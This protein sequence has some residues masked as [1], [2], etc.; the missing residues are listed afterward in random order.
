M[1]FITRR[2]FAAGVGAG[3]LAAPAV[4]RAQ[5]LFTRYPF[6]LGIASGDPSPDGFVIWTRL[7]PEP[8][9]PHGGMPLAPVEVEWSVARDP[10]MSDVAASG[11]GLARPELAHAVHVEVTGLAPDRPYWYRFRIGRERTMIG[12]ARTA[13]LPGARLDRLRFGVAGCQQYEDGLY[14][15]LR[16]LAAEEVAFVYHYGDYIYE[17]REEPVKLSREGWL[18]PFVRSSIGGECLTVDDYR[19][20]YAQYKMDQDLQAAHAA[21]PWFVTFDDHE[22]ANDWTN[23]STRWNTPAE[24]FAFRRAAAFQAWYEHM[25]V[26]RGA[27]PRAVDVQM[28]RRA[29]YGDLLDA[30]FLDTRQFRTPQPCGGGFGGDCDGVGNA[31]A[32]VLG[33]AQEGWLARGLKEPGARWAGIMQQV[34]MMRLDRRIAEGGAPVR[35]LDSWAG[36]LAPRDRVLR[37]LRARG[38]CVV[39]TGDEH[40]NFAGELRTGGGTGDVAA[41][42][43]VATS[44]SSGGN[45]GDKRVGADRIMAASQEL[46]FSN[47]QRGYLICDL[48]RDRWQTD[49]RVV[50]R[51]ETPGGTIDTRMSLTV[52]AG[53]PVLEGI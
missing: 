10:A 19:R 25:P 11:T 45:G 16:H 43:F 39:L 47:D 33:D 6:S 52:P 4:L 46:K 44:I 7:A 22:L 51:V 14:T 26:R 23:M 32:A 48:T 9:E 50:D 53:R 49:V 18:R 27:L 2:G 5:Q 34:M 30:F 8:L 36:Y 15:A 17:A 35:N 1:T 20:R 28:Y 24:L 38:D 12:R 40:Q 41:V 29:R 31:K 42:E 37:L 21:A 13:P 3:L